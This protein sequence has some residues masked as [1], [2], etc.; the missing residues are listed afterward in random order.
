MTKPGKDGHGD[1]VGEKGGNAA[2]RIVWYAVFKADSAC[3]D[4][5][6]LKDKDGMT[7]CMPTAISADSVIEQTAPA[8]KDGYKFKG[9][10][11]QKEG[12]IP[13][14]CFKDGDKTTLRITC[15]YMDVTFTAVY[16][17]TT[18]TAYSEPMPS[19]EEQAT[20]ETSTQS[21][22]EEEPTPVDE[23]I[24]AEAP[25]VIHGEMHVDLSGTLGS[26]LPAATHEPHEVVEHHEPVVGEGH[27]EPETAG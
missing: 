12:D 23:S 20:A 17:S 5:F 15:E 11:W 16:E 7:Y 27:V 26:D 24:P 19:A 9:W 21:I 3:C 18:E 8:A 2:S 13:E 14:E 4:G 6:D 1:S 22:P 25:Q 10:I